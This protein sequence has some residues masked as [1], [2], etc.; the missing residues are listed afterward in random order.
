M[1]CVNHSGVNATV[2][3]QN[4]GKPLCAACVRSTAGGLLFCESCWTAWQGYQQPFIPPAASGPNP[5]AA[6]ALGLIPG[7]GAMYNGQFVKGFIHVAIFAVLCAL[8][9]YNDYF[10]FGIAAWILYQSFEA[11]HTARALRD[12]LPLPD[13]LGLNEV[14]NWLTPNSRRQKPGQPGAGQPPAGEETGTAS[15]PPPYTGQYQ[16]PY[17]P[18]ATG[19]ANP[20]GQPIPPVPP[21]PP[22]C[23]HRNEPVGA[24]VLIALGVLFLVGQMKFAFP[25]LMIGLG[26]WLIVR[27]IE[28]SQGDSK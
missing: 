13:P 5:P 1:D 17:A 21:A 12:G 27:H 3:C 18:P 4:C 2:Y 25:L 16:P 22:Y 6:A 14:G 24:I 11:Y 19:F 7:V 10:G 20:N 26:V 15:T 8:A 28:D 23:W 9:N